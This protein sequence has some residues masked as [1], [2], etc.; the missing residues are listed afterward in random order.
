M[1]VGLF[2]LLGTGNLGND[3]SLSAVLGHLRKEHPR[4]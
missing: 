2:G 3:G 1:K 4:A